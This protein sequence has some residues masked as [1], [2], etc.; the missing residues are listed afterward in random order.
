MARRSRRRG[1]LADIFLGSIVAGAGLSLGRDSYK[2]VKKNAASAVVIAIAAFFIA[3]TGYAV[4]DMTRG[5]RRGPIATVLITYVFNCL[6]IGVSFGITY[7]FL[8]ENEAK[9]PNP[10]SPM[11]VFGVTVA[12]QLTLAA[13]GAFIGLR[14]RSRRLLQWDV[15]SHNERFLS[16]NGF[17]HVGGDNNTLI[18]PDGNELQLED[19]RLDALVFKVLGRRSVRAKI[20]LDPH[21]RMLTYVAP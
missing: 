16:T 4:W 5:H 6:M 21:G 3:G 18:A 15:E 19:E 2:L 20:T 12:I 14:Q 10:M 8:S 9:A 11:V 17:R 13:I 1:W 7:T